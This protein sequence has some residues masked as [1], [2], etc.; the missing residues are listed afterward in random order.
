MGNLTQGLAKTKINGIK[1][2][3]KKIV[4]KTLLKQS[5]K[6]DTADVYLK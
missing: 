3:F 2:S 1:R 6:L 4:G 5:N